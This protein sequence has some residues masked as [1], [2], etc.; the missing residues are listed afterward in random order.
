[1]HALSECLLATQIGGR[2]ASMKESS[3][4]E[5]DHTMSVRQGILVATSCVAV[6]LAACSGVG[7]PAGSA[8]T[9]GGEPT[10]GGTPGDGEDS[11]NDAKATMQSVIAEITA[12]EGLA[13][14]TAEQ[15]Q[16]ARVR[17]TDAR[18]RYNEAL[19]ALRT[20]VESLAGSSEHE[21]AV[22]Y[23]RGITLSDIPGR[24]NAAE[25]RASDTWAGVE[26]FS[27]SSVA[28]PPV[29]RFERFP[30]AEDDGTVIPASERL[31]IQTK[32]VMHSAGKTVFSAGGTGVTDELPM[33]SLTVRSAGGRGQRGDWDLQG[34]DSSPN[35]LGN[36]DGVLNYS[37]QITPTGLVYKARGNA[38]YYDFQR[39]FDMGDDADDWYGRGP[40]GERG[41]ADDG[42]GSGKWDGCYSRSGATSDCTN[43]IHDDIMVTFGTPSQPSRGVS[44]FYWRTRIPFPEGTTWETP[45]IVSKIST[46]G[47]P[48]GP[49]SDL[50][51]YD[52]WISN[53][54]GVDQGLE[55]DDGTAYPEDDKDRFLKYAAYGVFIYVDQ[56]VSTRTAA[57]QQGFH[58]GYDTFA[59]QD[60]LRTT[61]IASDDVVEATFQGAT[62]AIQYLLSNTAHPNRHELRGN[63]TL[64]ARIGS[65][66]NTISGE[67]T[68]LER[69]GS[70][71]AWTNF[72]NLVRRT[73]SEPNVNRDRLVFAGK[74][75]PLVSKTLVDESR[76]DADET[77]DVVS[78]YANDYKAYGATINADGS[79][80]GGVY[81]HNWLPDNEV[82]IEKSWEFDSY[83]ANSY[84]VFGG[85]IYGPRDGD[86]E[87][88]ETAGY[89]YLHGDRRVSNWGGII[90]SFGAVRTD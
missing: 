73:E 4:R 61:D 66:A 57:R 18:T 80:E 41:T 21:N 79:Y 12:I 35:T 59:D 89:W 29:A 51:F 78:T 65:G 77:G 55:F 72:N 85:T 43:W 63:I 9:D 58:F 34:R 68:N 74:D 20:A 7:T 8:P 56:L 69:L 2:F 39:R 46:H 40:D 13:V 88:I 24:L 31:S 16:A 47:V 14:A 64:N 70:D 82:W 27:R 86:F 54:G 3:E 37:V 36:T 87:N 25:L 30:R 76:T 26:G 44:A 5:R 52:L 15:K 19:A 53:F 90:G 6:L 33:R 38:I 67:L 11:Y 62:T 28:T 84:S 1:M 22:N 32:A 81:L 83:R 50:G 23:L 17:V 42:P 48:R 10:D 45:N 60:N 75:Y 71:G 49:E